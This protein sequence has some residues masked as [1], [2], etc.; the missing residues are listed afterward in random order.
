MLSKDKDQFIRTE[1]IRTHRLELPFPN[2]LPNRK[3]AFIAS[4]AR[5]M[6]IQLS[7][8]KPWISANIVNKYISDPYQ[9]SFVGT[10]EP[11]EMGSATVI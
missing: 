9:V 11:G 10:A 2:W 6:G 7:A 4:N 3:H 8:L 1:F 5:K